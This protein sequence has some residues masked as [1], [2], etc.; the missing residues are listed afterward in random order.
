MSDQPFEPEENPFRKHRGIVFI[1]AALGILILLGFAG[2]VYGIALKASKSEV[3]E[4]NSTDDDARR[5]G[6]SAISPVPR[7]AEGESVLGMTAG[8][9]NVY[10]SLR[11]SDGR[12]VLRGFDAQGAFLFE[13]PLETE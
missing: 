8:D 9:G 6:A 4:T 11:L 3:V 10:V 2:L 13:T 12:I 1:V 7:I 5:I